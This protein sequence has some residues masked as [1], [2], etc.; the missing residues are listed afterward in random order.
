MTAISTVSQSNRILGTFTVERGEQEQLELIS[1][2]QLGARSGY[3]SVDAAIRAVALLTRGPGPSVG[4]MRV[5][6]RFYAYQ[7][8]ERNLDAALTSPLTR[9]SLAPRTAGATSFRTNHRDLQLEAIVDG[10]FT[11]RFRG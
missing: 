9:A 1:G 6:D 8:L 11:H 2:R 3:G 5:Q 4:I 7:L 10:A